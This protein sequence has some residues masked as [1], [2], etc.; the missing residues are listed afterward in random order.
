M[1]IR[2]HKHNHL[3]QRKRQT[4]HG[5]CAGSVFFVFL[6][7]LNRFFGVSVCLMDIIFGKRC[8]GCGLTRGFIAVLQLDFKAATTFH[9]LSV[10]LFFGICLYCFFCMVD[11]V[12]RKEF[13]MKIEKQ[14]AKKYMLVLYSIIL[15]AAYLLNIV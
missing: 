15:V 10:P 6:Y 3:P 2:W 9:V 11:I 7:F 1:D 5:I 13:I 4:L 12:F 8:P 14:M